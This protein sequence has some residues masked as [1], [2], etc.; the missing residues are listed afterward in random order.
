M[1]ARRIKVGTNPLKR[2]TREQY[3]AHTSRRK[4]KER[5][6]RKQRP[7]FFFRNNA[8]DYQLASTDQLNGTLTIRAVVEGRPRVIFIDTG[9]NISLIQPGAQLT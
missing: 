3:V 2:E 7:P 8:A 9:S 1:E 4:T 6:R 5:W